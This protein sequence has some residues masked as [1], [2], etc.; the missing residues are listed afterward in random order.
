MKYNI[1]LQ[2]FGAQKESWKTEKSFD[3]SCLKFTLINIYMVLSVD[4]Q[5]KMVVVMYNTNRVKNLK[6][7]MFVGIL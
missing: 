3:T 6:S 2:Y 5:F 7:E 4:L 1:G